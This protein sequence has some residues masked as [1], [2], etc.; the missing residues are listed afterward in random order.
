MMHTTEVVQKLGVGE[1]DIVASFVDSPLK[2]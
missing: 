1:T 2:G